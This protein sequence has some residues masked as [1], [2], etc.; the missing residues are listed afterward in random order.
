MPRQRALEFF[1]LGCRIL[2]CYGAILFFLAAP[3]VITLNQYITKLLQPFLRQSDLYIKPSI[4][5]TSRAYATAQSLDLVWLGR[6]TK[7]ALTRE[8]V[9]HLLDVH[10]IF[11]WMSFLVGCAVILT[12]LLEKEIIDGRV[13]RDSRRVILVLAVTS[14]V[15]V[16]AF[17][18]FFEGFHQVFFP[19]GNYSFSPN[20]LIIQCFP[21]LFWVANL[22]WLQCAVIVLLWW[23]ALHAQ[24]LDI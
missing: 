20:S 9:S 19:Q 2:I 22:I 10:Q 11:I 8:E 1:F 5:E 13:A 15:G 7:D 6:S 16:V 18:P 23:Q 4:T 12:V 14:L 17:P 3:P 21:P 24:R